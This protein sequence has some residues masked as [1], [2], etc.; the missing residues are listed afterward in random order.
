MFTAEG[1]S[2]ITVRSGEMH[3]VYALY[4]CSR[5][6]AALRGPNTME[7]TAEGCKQYEAFEVEPMRGPTMESRFVTA[8]ALL[9]DKTLYVWGAKHPWFGGLQMKL[10]WGAELA[11]APTRVILDD[12]VDG[13]EVGAAGRVRDFK[14]FGGTTEALLLLL[15]DDGRELAMRIDADG[16]VRPEQVR[17][18]EPK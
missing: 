12:L 9:G 17:W 6:R 18:T 7:C 15:L 10:A 1:K 13:G 11:A 4:G 3:R 8:T 2:A 14:L 5:G 16:S